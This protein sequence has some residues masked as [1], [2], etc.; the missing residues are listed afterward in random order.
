MSIRI[1][2]LNYKDMIFFSRT[3]GYTGAEHCLEFQLS[4]VDPQK[5]IT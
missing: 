2:I 1:Y 4:K 5:G 3:R